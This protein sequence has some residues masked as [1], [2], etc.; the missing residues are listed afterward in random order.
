MERQ[1]ITFSANEQNL[2]KTGGIDNYASNTVSYVVATFDLGENWD[3]FDSVRAVF[4]SDYETVPAVLAHDSCLVPFEVLRYRSTVRVN[5][6]GSVVVAGA[7]VDRLTSFPI[8][9]LTVTANAK[10]DNSIAPISPSEFEE[11]VAMVKADADRAEA[12]AEAAEDSAEAASTSAG[13]ASTS[14]SN[15]STSED[16]AKV[17]E[18][19]AEAYKNQAQGYAQN[20]QISATNAENAKDEAIDARDEI[21]GM[22]ANATTLS[23]GSDATASYA[24]GVL[25]LGIPRGNTGATGPQ[26]PQGPQ[27]ETGPQGPK[28]DTGD[29]SQEQLDAAVTD[30]KAEI[31]NEGVVQG[32]HGL[33]SDAKISDSVPYTFR[34]TADGQ[35]VGNVVYEEIVGG[36]VAFNQIVQNGNFESTTGWR[37]VNCTRTASNNI[38]SISATTA[39][40]TAQCY[41]NLSTV[42]G[43]KY[44]SVATMKSS[45]SA[46]VSLRF[47]GYFDTRSLS[48]NT[49]TDFGKIAS[50]GNTS[51]EFNFYFTVPE[52]MQLDVKNAMCFDLTQM[53]G[54][55][56]ADHLYQLETATAGAGVAWFKKLFP[57]PYYAYNSGE[58]KSVEGVSA[59]VTTGF[60]AW[61]EEW[62]NG[63]FDANG[64]IV[65]NNNT[66]YSKNYI[67]VI[68]N[69]AYYFKADGQ[70]RLCYY[71]ADKT[72]I[73]RSDLTGG[74]T[75][76]TIPSDCHYIRF[77]NDGTSYNPS[78]APICINIAWDNSRN[79][80]YE[81]YQKRTYALDSTLTLRGIPKLS[82][83]KIYYDGDTYD[84]DGTV[85]RKYGIVDMGTLNWTLGSNSTFYIAGTDIGLKRPA[86]SNDAPTFVSAKYD[87]V[88]YTDATS[89]TTGV[90]F[91]TWETS[92]SNYL[93]IKD[94]S[95]STAAAF[96]T[97]MSGV[98]L[99]YELA[100][101]TTETAEP[102]TNPQI[103]DRYGT[104][105]YVT[106]GIVPIGHNSKYSEDLKGKLE[107]LPWNFSALIAPTETTNKA[108]RNYTTGSLLIMNNVLYKA[109]A[110][111]QSGGTITPN[112]NVVATTL[113]EVIANL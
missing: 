90:I 78:T 75:A 101:P 15:A 61:D 14:A 2:I 71:D 98:Y 20:A 96:K 1:A 67:P 45:V 24:N 43:H 44:L 103:V 40:Q 41:R 79:G 74:N 107:E 9:A 60:N 55:T 58:L 4:S 110:N 70:H 38:L 29:V 39:G 10:V 59:H 37:N 47:E 5:L 113:A 32:S 69:T 54:T 106:T 36:T 25:S 108:S 23:P 109:T 95:Y 63:N 83:G 26:G 57:K 49:W 105:E 19:N 86:S 81:P 76:F 56:I 112:T 27:G 17:S 12:G 99:V 33:V 85:T 94:T 34:Q 80:Q 22:T 111:I 65:A 82:D 51:T 7:L 30:L 66:F 97:A 50:A 13:A 48:V 64:D 93:Y 89:R 100:T 73:S 88:K 62:A 18:L 42:S 92:T 68:P 6:V 77:H 72:F 46:N 52:S 104:E 91:T 87:A 21:R 11:F 84:A 3:E 31:T 35:R 28:G 102:Y 53:F 8:T 16:N